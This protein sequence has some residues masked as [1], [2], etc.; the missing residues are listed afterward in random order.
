MYCG[1]SNKKTPCAG[2]FFKDFNM[3]G[4]G[5]QEQ[6]MNCAY[7]WREREWVEHFHFAGTSVR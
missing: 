6:M 2:R 5:R 1:M 4:D 7:E 3:I